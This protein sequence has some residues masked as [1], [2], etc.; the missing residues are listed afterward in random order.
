MSALALL[1]G[2]ERTWRELRG[3]DCERAHHDL[4]IQDE[5]DRREPCKAPKGS[6]SR[7]R[8][9]TAK[10]RFRVL[11]P[12]ARNRRQRGP[13]RR[14]SGLGTSPVRRECWGGAL[15]VTYRHSG[16]CE[17]SY[18]NQRSRKELNHSV[19]PL[20]LGSP[21]QMGTRV[22][23]FSKNFLTPVQRY[24]RSRRSVTLQPCVVTVR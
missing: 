8:H 3:E 6:L 22:V 2:A 5:G 13:I 23:L 11:G 20:E 1:L 21:L 17:H 12:L 4:K 10:N 14:V 18:A 15:G 16:S 24:A 7:G 9:G 19:S